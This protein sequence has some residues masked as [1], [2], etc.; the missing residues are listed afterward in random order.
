MSIGWAAENASKSSSP[1]LLVFTTFEV[2]LPRFF[3]ILQQLVLLVGTCVIAYLYLRLKTKLSHAKC[4][5]K[6]HFSKALVQK[7]E[8]E[9]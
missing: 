1:I 3:S 2:S 7:L 8:P 6:Y 5:S 9:V 4:S